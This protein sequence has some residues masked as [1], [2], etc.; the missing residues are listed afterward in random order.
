MRSRSSTRASVPAAAAAKR[1]TSASL[2][3]SPRSITEA[4]AWLP[5]T[6]AAMAS[7]RMIAD[8]GSAA[9]RCAVAA[10]RSR[11]QVRSPSGAA[12]FARTVRARDSKPRTDPTMAAVSMSFIESGAGSPLN[13]TVSVSATCAG[14]SYGSRPSAAA[15]SPQD[16]QV[17]RFASVAARASSSFCTST[18]AAGVRAICASAFAASARMPTPS[19]SAG[20]MSG[21]ISGRSNRP[22]ARIAVRRPLPF[23]PS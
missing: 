3:L 6:S 14:V 18:T 8:R 15:I 23:K 7:R 10:Q 1:R 21:I 20:A 9:G 19:F 17:F 13:S 5:V 11:S 12:F 2:S 22:I 16:S 4:V